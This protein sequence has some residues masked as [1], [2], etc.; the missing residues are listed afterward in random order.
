MRHDFRWVL[1][2]HVLASCI[3]CDLVQIDK[4]PDFLPSTAQRNR[5]PLRP[6]LKTIIH[7]LIIRLHQQEIDIFNS[8]IISTNT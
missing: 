8:G 1:L 2:V 7:S 4:F 5:H 6:N 3:G